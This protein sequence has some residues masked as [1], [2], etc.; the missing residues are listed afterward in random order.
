MD[1]KKYGLTFLE[2]YQALK[3]GKCVR[4]SAWLGYWQLDGENI[5][6]RRKDGRVIS[7]KEGCLP[8]FTL[9]NT[10]EN[11]WLIVDDSHN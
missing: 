9:G 11:D 6:M 4:R 7:M 10:L 2:A 3:E 8:M 5:L 1:A